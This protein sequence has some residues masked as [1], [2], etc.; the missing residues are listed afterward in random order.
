MFGLPRPN[1][2]PCLRCWS[3][4][5]ALGLCMGSKRANNAEQESPKMSRLS[6]GTHSSC[7]NEAP[8]GRRCHC[9]PRVQCQKPSPEDTCVSGLPSFSLEIFELKDTCMGHTGIHTL[10]SWTYWHRHD[11]MMTS[12]ST[13][14]PLCSTSSAHQLLSKIFVIYESCQTF[15][16]PDGWQ[17]F[18]RTVIYFVH[19]IKLEQRPSPKGR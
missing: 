4:N 19:F 9:L 3:P 2:Q 8:P 16:V 17:Y 10:C 7:L 15:E 11:Q 12:E 18:L 5:T 6:E 13:S 1:L 14:V